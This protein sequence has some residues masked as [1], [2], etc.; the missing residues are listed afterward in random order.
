M[1]GHQCKNGGF[2]FHRKQ[3]HR[4]ENVQSNNDTWVR[5]PYAYLVVEFLVVI[6]VDRW[7]NWDPSLASCCWHSAKPIRSVCPSN[8][9]T[10]LSCNYALDG[11]Q[12]L[13]SQGSV[14]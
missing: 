2:F 3:T 7:I 4:K 5:Y 13:C 12:V 9:G 10:R 6:V 14:N 11:K 1:C 8:D